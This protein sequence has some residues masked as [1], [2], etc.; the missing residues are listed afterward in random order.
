MDYC[1]EDSFYLYDYHLFPRHR[2]AFSLIGKP[3]MARSRFHW[4]P[5]R[6]MKCDQLNSVQHNSLFF[7][8]FPFSF[9][10]FQFVQQ[11]HARKYRYTWINEES[12]KYVCCYRGDILRANHKCSSFLLHCQS[13]ATLRVRPN[14]FCAGNLNWILFPNFKFRFQ[15]DNHKEN[16]IKTQLVE[17]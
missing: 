6:Q 10:F 8:F 11:W 15:I 5:S 16:W 7:W 9:Y 14:L 12:M 4:F 1:S 2:H 17:T 3:S 13:V